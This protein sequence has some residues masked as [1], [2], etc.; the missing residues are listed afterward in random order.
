MITAE[1]VP[2]DLLIKRLADYLKENVKEVKPKEWSFYA[3]TASYNERVPDNP[4]EWWYIRA[5]SLLRKLYLKGP[6]GVSRLRSEYSWRKRRGSRPP[7]SVKAPGHAIRVMMQQLEKAGLVKS[8]KE[9]RILTGKGR[10]LIDKLSYE[11]FK[12]LAEKNPELSKY[13]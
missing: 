13:L 10:S 7:K 5:A 4:E 3:K 1:M 12:S 9:G 2:A 6:I 8:T 11:I